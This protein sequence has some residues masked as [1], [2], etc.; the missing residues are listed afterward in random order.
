M[1]IVV[2]KCGVG[3]QLFQYH[4]YQK[5]KQEGHRVYYKDETL[6]HMAHNGLEIDKYF[7]IDIRPWPWLVGVVLRLV[8][9]F[10]YRGYAALACD[11][12]NYNERKLIFQGFW[13]DKK[14]MHPATLI[15]FKTDLPLSEKN[16]VL[17]HEMQQSQSVAIHVRRGDYLKPD[18]A[19]TYGGICTQQYYK[20]AIERVE[21]KLKNPRFY[22]FSD[23]IAWCKAN[24]PINNAQYVDWNTGND[25][26]Y[27]MYLMSQCKANIIANSTFSYWGAKIG[28]PLVVVYPKRWFADRP[29]PDLFPD[30]WMG[31]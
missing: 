7:D 17:A 22:V 25:S 19:K 21:Q 2:L 12:T 15:R 28:K 27:D 9:K 24:L 14:Y 5:L 8:Y 13:Q 18:C 1:K 20:E 4:L 16:K 31:I 3:N 26:I 23:D 30:D 11:D 10:F 6:W 29:A